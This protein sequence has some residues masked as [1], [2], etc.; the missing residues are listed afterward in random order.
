MLTAGFVSLCWFGF[1]ES[2]EEVELQ[3]SGSDDDQTLESRP[4]VHISGVG[5]KQMVN[6]TMC[7]TK[8]LPM[9]KQPFELVGMDLIGKLTTTESGNQSL[10][11]L[12][13]DKP[14]EW[15]KHLDAVM[16]GLRTK[17]Q[18]TT[19]FSPYFLMFGRE[20]RYPSEIPENYRID[21]TVEDTLSV[22]EVTESAIKMSE[23]LKEAESNIA[24]CQERVRKQRK[25]PLT[26]FNVGDKVWRQNVRMEQRKGGKLEPNFLGPYRIASLEGKSAGLEDETG[27][28]IPKINIDHLRHCL[29][30]VPRIPHKLKRRASPSPGPVISNAPSSAASPSPGPVISNAPSSAASPSPG[31]VISNAPFRPASPSSG[32]VISN[33]PFRPATPSPGPVISNA[34]S[35]AASPSPGPVISNAPFRPTSPSSDPVVSSASSSAVAGCFD[36]E[37]CVREAW[38]GKNV[39]VLLSKIGPFKLFYADILRTAPSQQLESEVMNAY[40]YHLVQKYNQHSKE[41]AVYI[42]SFEMTNIW[43]QKR[44]KT[45][46]MIPQE[47][48]AL[49]LDPLGESKIKIKRCQDVTR[50]FMRQRGCNFSRWG[51]DKLPH[52]KQQ[53]G[54]SCGPFVL[55]FAECILKNEPLD[56]STSPQDVAELRMGIAICL[57]QNTDDLTDLCFL[58]GERDGPQN[59]TDWLEKLYALGM[60]PLLLIAHPPKM[61]TGTHTY[62]TKIMLPVHTQLST[63]AKTCLENVNAIYKLMVEGEI[64]LI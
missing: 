1:E 56:F 41:K 19:K 17:R 2:L 21:K 10:C 6:C 16:F 46:V 33:A 42:D 28:V 38:G 11:K 12:V 9:V 23:I 49:F 61:V 45:K 60:K 3:V 62:Q 31:P 57:L 47:K 13:G 50:S 55:K 59:V 27:V 39:Y 64:A 7:G 34:P 24:A 37:K 58:C 54:S 36:T 35:S 51:C 30:E 43:Q 63:S 8:A 53:D 29:E 26:K 52:A 32:P 18:V 4:A 48:R 44:A 15:D 40:M 5:L 14:N 25:R 20:A 22:E